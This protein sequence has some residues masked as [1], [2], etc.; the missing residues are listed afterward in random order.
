VIALT[1]SVHLE[2]GGFD[3]NCEMAELTLERR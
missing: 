1:F 3:A 2:N